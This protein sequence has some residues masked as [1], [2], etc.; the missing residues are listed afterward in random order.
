M[1]YIKTNRIIK[2]NKS[3]NLFGILQNKCSCGGE[4]LRVVVEFMSKFKKVSG[5]KFQRPDRWDNTASGGF[6]PR[7]GNVW[8]S[9]DICTKEI[10]E[11]WLK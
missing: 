2:F 9:A 1:A 6:C 5:F 8:G 10:R 7:C 4:E 3:F 11:A